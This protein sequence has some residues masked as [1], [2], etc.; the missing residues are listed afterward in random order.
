MT[1]ETCCKHLFNVQKARSNSFSASN[2]GW[3]NREDLPDECRI[4]DAPLNDYHALTLDRFIQW[5]YT[6]H[7]IPTGP[8]AFLFS[9]YTH[10]NPYFVVYDLH[11][12]I[13][14]KVLP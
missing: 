2:Y 8:V 6:T 13:V 4:L 1:S 14:D 12:H 9:K 7:G 11:K 10:S 5:V 3:Y